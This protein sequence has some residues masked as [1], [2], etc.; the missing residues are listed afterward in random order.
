MDEEGA[1]GAV[2]QAPAAPDAR[3]REERRERALG[4]WT[5]VVVLVLAATAFLVFV[6]QNTDE[7]AVEW[8][9]WSVGV[10][11]AAVVF[12]S[13]LLGAV[14]ALAAVTAWRLRRHRRLREREELR[15]LRGGG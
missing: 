2:E 5:S 8:T 1:G 4:V 11:L 13:M 12:G 15:R 14:G 6:A 3:G 10:S 7:V 9:V